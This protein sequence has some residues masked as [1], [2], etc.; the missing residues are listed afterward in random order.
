MNYRT[1]KARGFWRDPWLLG[2]PFL[3][4]GFYNYLFTGPLANNA[5]LFEW[6]PMEIRMDT[7][8]PDS[9]IDKAMGI[10]EEAHKVV[11]SGA[12]VWVVN[13]I[14]HQSSTSPMILKSL[15]KSLS[16]CSDDWLI[17]QVLDHYS[18]L[19][20]PYEHPIDRAAT[21]PVK[22]KKKLKVKGKPELKKKLL[23][24]RADYV[25]D[26]YCK[27]LPDLPQPRSIE[28][29]R[30]DKLYTML[31]KHPDEWFVELFTEAS[32]QAFLFGINDRGWKATFDFFLRPDKALL[33]LEG[34]YNNQVK[35]GDR[36]IDEPITGAPET[37]PDRESQEE[38]Q[39]KRKD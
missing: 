26:Q 38:L 22:Y 6:S 9:Q 2:Q 28:G 13:F 14:K 25:V 21:P 27:L 32:K 16:E 10:L 12:W 8:L 1:I 37:P 7:A 19:A 15:G 39:Q 30:K 31:Q 3:V 34:S 33:V 23:A 35:S 20:I 36:R 29:K 11:V 4:K 18:H 5:G 17:G 24:Q